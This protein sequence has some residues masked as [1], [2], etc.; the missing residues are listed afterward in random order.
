MPHSRKVSLL[1]APY[2]CPPLKKGDRVMRKVR[3]MSKIT[4]WSRGRFPWLRCKGLYR[5]GGDGLLLDDELA[6]AV[7]T[8]SAL[9]IMYWWGVSERV[10]WRW[11]RFLGV[12]HFGTPGS[13][14]LIELNRRKPRPPLKRS[15]EQAEQR[16]QRI[17]VLR[18][19]RS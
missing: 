19:K 16:R 9:A 14:R 18:L 4:G 3:G 12:K 11:R 7:R 5:Q 15:P 13:Q 17:F 6:R 1:G 8:E 10:V 2:R